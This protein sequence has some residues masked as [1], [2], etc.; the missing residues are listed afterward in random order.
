VLGTG[1][2]AS[3]GTA[4]AAGSAAL[5]TNDTTVTDGGVSGYFY[6]LEPTSVAMPPGFVPTNVEASGP[7]SF[8]VIG[9]VGSQPEFFQVVT[10]RVG[11]EGTQ[12]VVVG[13]HPVIYDGPKLQAQ[14]VAILESG[15]Y[16]A[17][18]EI[19]DAGASTRPDFCLHVQVP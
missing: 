8:N 1:T 9:S 16:V 11:A 12:P 3:V 14:A 18:N 19:T 15:A 5:V 4:G 7:D 17:V 6:S 13:P 2:A 10:V